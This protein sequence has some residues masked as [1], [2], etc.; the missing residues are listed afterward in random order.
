[1]GLFLF[2]LLGQVLEFRVGALVLDVVE[3]LPVF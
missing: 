3:E 2:E 1:M